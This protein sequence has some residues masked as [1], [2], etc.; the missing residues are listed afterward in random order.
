M[1]NYDLVGTGDELHHWAA[2]QNGWGKGVPNVIKNNPLNL[3]PMPKQAHQLTHNNLPSQGLK[4]YGP[5][6]RYG[7]ATPG[8][9]KGGTVG[10][11]AHA[12]GAVKRQT[13]E[14]R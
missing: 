1:K 7:A 5:L 4:K 2:P 13:D 8:W 14:R 10:A 6:Q 3:N 12:T 11:G 9:A